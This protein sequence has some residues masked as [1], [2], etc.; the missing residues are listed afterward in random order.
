MKK[1]I[2]LTLLALATISCKAQNTIIDLVDRCNHDSNYRNGS[3][4]L[5]DT[6][7]L[8]LPFVGTWKWTEGNRELT[9]TLIKQ[10]KYHYT[11][12]N[13]NYYDDRIVGFY[14]YKENGV[15]L[16]STIN[17]N[18][19]N[20]YGIKVQLN[21]DC[22]SNLYVVNFEDVLKNKDYEGWVELIADNRIKF[23]LKEDTHMQIQREGYPALPPRYVGN[24]FPLDI[25]L[26]KQ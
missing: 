22:G 21:L 2:F 24:T 23:H 9:L 14:N 15:V 8:Y 20:E 25:V 18:L 26:I 7:N 6:H 19:N 11:R 17:D 12:G 3:T 16:A 1:T 10:T 13:Y 4:Y 5:K